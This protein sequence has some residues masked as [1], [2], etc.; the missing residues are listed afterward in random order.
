MIITIFTDGASRGN[1]GPGGWG[2]VSVYE[3]ADA[4]GVVG[5]C[6]KEGGGAERVATNNQMELL[7]A[8]RALE[9][10]STQKKSGAVVADDVVVHSDSSYMINGITKWVAG[11]KR[12]GWITSTKTPVENRELW[13]GLDAVTAHLNADGIQVRWQYVGG[14]IGVK[15]NERCDVIA[16]ALATGKEVVP[17]LYNGHF[18]AYPIADV[19][20]ISHSMEK[21]KDK[22]AD[23][24][25]SKAT[26]YSYVSAVNGDVQTHRTWKECEARVK[27]VRG[28][29][30]KKALSA[31]E[32]SII[33]TEFS[34]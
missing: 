16:T 32:E 12:K 7:A 31:T 23:R 21:K 18:S 26:A 10:V 15:G 6:V 24:S 29:R 33:S 22:G 28:A 3:K 4:S 27:G 30:F 13:E 2:F 19:L 5:R 9:Y 14:H 20:D 11:W 34:A 17:A 8:L 25:R 1:P